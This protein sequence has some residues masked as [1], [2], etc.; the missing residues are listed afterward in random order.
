MMRYSCHEIVVGRCRIATVG[1]EAAAG[2]AQ[3]NIAEKFGKAGG[4]K[5]RKTEQ[6]KK[7]AGQKKKNDDY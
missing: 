6:K 7:K 1:Q 3:E 4:K 5:K 2:I